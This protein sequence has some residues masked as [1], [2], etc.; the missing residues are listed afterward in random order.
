MFKRWEEG[1][2]REKKGGGVFQLPWF[3]LL[4]SP[5]KNYF[6]PPP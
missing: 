1:A 4:P 3:T 6:L 2:K 5:S